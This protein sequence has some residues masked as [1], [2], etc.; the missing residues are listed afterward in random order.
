MN[1]SVT[2]PALTPVT[3]PALV[4]VAMALLLLLQV[5]PVAGVTLAVLPGQ[6]V[7]APPV[8]PVQFNV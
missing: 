6:T 4:T 7:V 8:L 3:T 2:D 5:P 1:V